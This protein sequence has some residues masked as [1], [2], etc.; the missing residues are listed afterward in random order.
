MPLTGELTCVKS[1]NVTW[2]N[3][4][5]IL[6]RGVDHHLMTSISASSAL[7]IA[8][9]LDPISFFLMMTDKRVKSILKKGGVIK[10]P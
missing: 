5:T 8:L 6:D 2:I 3:D 7:L 9:A 4:L 1:T 10:S